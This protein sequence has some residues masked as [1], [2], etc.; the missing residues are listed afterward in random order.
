MPEKVH[1]EE[2]L[3]IQ[4]IEK[5]TFW[6]DWHLS[7][8]QNQSISKH[9]F[10]NFMWGTYIPSLQFALHIDRIFWKSTK[11]SRICLLLL[12][13]KESLNKVWSGF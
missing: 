10:A 8:S 13:K 2:P 12:G 6:G 9:L 5:I 3:G 7:F 11:V 1:L 4:G